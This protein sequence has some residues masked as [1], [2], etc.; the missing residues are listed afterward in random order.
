MEQIS[1]IT[2]LVYL[3]YLYYYVMGQEPSIAPIQLDGKN[4]IEDT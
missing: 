3:G 4:L 2:E 1:T